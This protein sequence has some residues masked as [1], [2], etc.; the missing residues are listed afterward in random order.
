MSKIE[1]EDGEQSKQQHNM[2]THQIIKLVALRN[3]QI[4]V[5]IKSFRSHPSPVR[6]SSLICN[7]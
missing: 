7:L 4:F 5:D 1:K 3:N 6:N 2:E